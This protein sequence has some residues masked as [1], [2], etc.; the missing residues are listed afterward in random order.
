MALVKYICSSCG[1]SVDPQNMA[2]GV[3]RCPYCGTAHEKEPERPV[4]PPPVIHT[5]NAP[6]TEPEPPRPI[7][8]RPKLSG[9]LLALAI[10]F[11]WPIAIVYFIVIH[12]KQKDWDAAQARHAAWS[13]RNAPRNSG[14][15]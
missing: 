11:V 3:Y 5:Y 12:Y 9:C 7:G 6:P 8:P 4:P 1:A 10:V 15:R 2:G 14:W 13:A